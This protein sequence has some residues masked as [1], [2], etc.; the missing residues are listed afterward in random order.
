MEEKIEVKGYVRAYATP[1]SKPSAV[2]VTTDKG[3][4]TIPV[5]DSTSYPINLPVEVSIS[6]KSENTDE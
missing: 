2:I 4:I 6:V 1:F 5:S 3:D